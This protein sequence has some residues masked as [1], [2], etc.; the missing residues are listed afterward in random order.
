ME[1]WITTERRTVL[2]CGRFLSVEEHQV[3]LPNGQTI[4]DWPWVVAPSYAIVVALTEDRRV[5]CLRQVKYAIDGVSLALAG[6]YVEEGEQPLDAARRELLEE[7]G[8]SADGWKWLG[9]YVVDANRGVGMA[10]LYLATDTRQIRNPDADDLEEQE[11]VILS[12]DDF[13]SAVRRGEFKALSWA[14]A[15]SLALLHLSG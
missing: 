9:D 11:L 6:G 5:L 15:A 13:R 12:L 2:T 8:C 4:S 1:P 10:Y 3:Q 14:A 7:T